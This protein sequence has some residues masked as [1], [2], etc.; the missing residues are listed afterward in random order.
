[1]AS[2]TEPLDALTAPERHIF[3]SP[4]YDDIALSTGGTVRLLADQ[5][6]SPET[7]VIFGA[8]PDPAAPL[9]PFAQA[10][11]KGWGLSAN[12]VI[13]SRQAEERAASDILGARA[14]VLPFHD[15]IYREQHYLS[16]D[17]LF[18]T[19]AAA[20]HDLP[21]QIAGSL[22]LPEA[23]DQTIRIYAPL[24]IGRHV[25][26]QHVF[27]TG[28][29]LAEQGWQ[30]WLYEDTPYTL[31]PGVV[32]ARLEEITSVVGTVPAALVPIDTAWNAKINAI[33]SYPSQLETIFLQYVGVGANR[34]E[35]SSA[36]S[37]YARHV[38]EG[39]LAERY[40]EVIYASS[41]AGS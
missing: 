34:E 28:V 20:E 21:A 4:H 3:L 41:S 7:L 31:K 10:M 23:P 27:R 18:G 13:A 17:D 40:W 25:D 35:I 22:G 11:H 1:M 32:E 6:R 8:E 5:G 19:P 16:D 36:L 12:A 39:N 33:L 37:R 15:A 9:T 24:A 26:H 2:H 38:G 14:R 30:V 29:L